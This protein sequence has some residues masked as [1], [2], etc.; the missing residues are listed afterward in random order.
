MPLATLWAEADFVSE[1]KKS[2][3][4]TLAVLIHA[5]IVDVVAGGKTLKAA[6]EE[7]TDG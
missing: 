5:A 3:I 2:E 4:G 7:L 6:L 1:S